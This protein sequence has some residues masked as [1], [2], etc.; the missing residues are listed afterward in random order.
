MTVLNWIGNKPIE[1]TDDTNSENAPVVSKEFVG[2]EKHVWAKDSIYK[3]QNAGII[4]GVSDSEFAPANNIKRGDFILILT[5]MLNTDAVVTD[6]FSDAPKDSYYYDSIAKA[7]VTFLAGDI[8]KDNSINIYD[9]SAVVSYFGT[10]DLKT[11]NATMAKHVQ[12]LKKL[13]KR[14]GRVL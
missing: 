9:L 6:N 12:N 14:S 3:L 13:I 8:V 5:R 2:L 4:S 11:T 10:I 1:K 7:K